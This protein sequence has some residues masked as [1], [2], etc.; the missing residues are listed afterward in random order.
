MTRLSNLPF[1]TF[2]YSGGE[3]ILRRQ[4]QLMFQSDP[5]Q[6]GANRPVQTWDEEAER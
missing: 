5:D 1:K 6:E 2:T 3:A 4:R